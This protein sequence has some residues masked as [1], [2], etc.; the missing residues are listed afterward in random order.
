M[1]MAAPIVALMFVALCIILIALNKP[2][3]RS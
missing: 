1:L 3:V 2:E